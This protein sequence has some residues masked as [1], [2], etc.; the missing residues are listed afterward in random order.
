M[1]LNYSTH[2][3]IARIVKLKTCFLEFVV[4]LKDFLLDLVMKKVFLLRDLVE[5]TVTA[6]NAC[7]FVRCGNGVRELRGMEE[8]QN[9]QWNAKTFGKPQIR[10]VENSRKGGLSMILMI[11]MRLFHIKAAT[12]VFGYAMRFLMRLQIGVPN[13]QYLCREAPN[14]G[15]FG[16]N[17]QC[18]S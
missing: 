16:I 2:T 14:M 17:R 18:K 15:W 1:E 12:C 8:I 13:L 10:H 4:K 11:R 6:P 5:L 9:L 3:G 7:H